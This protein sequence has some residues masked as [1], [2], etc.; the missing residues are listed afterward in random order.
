V[1]YFGLFRV[2]NLETVSRGGAGSFGKGLGVSG[3]PGPKSPTLEKRG[4]GHP[5]ARR[6]PGKYLISAQNVLVQDHYKGDN[7]K[8]NARHGTTAARV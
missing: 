4:A 8:V 1:G 3:I 7:R 2:Q 6:E 5:A